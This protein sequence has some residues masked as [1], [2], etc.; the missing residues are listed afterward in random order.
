MRGKAGPAVTVGLAQ[1]RQGEGEGGT[2]PRS[3]K[4]LGWPLFWGQQQVLGGERKHTRGP[5]A[6]DLAPPP[7]QPLLVA[8]PPQLPGRKVVERLGQGGQLSSGHTL[9]SVFIS[10]CCA[11]INLP[12]VYTYSC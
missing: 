10:L 3:A 9:A 11:Y 1:D 5:K 6:L 12:L 8:T 4:D 2:L 7:K